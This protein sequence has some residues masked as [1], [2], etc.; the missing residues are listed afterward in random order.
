MSL[1]KRKK[2][3]VAVGTFIAVLAIF[4]IALYYCEREWV[5]ISG[6]EGELSKNT[7]LDAG[8]GMEE[9]SSSDRIFFQCNVKSGS[10]IFELSDTSGMIVFRKEFVS[11][12]MGYFY[13]DHVSEGI[14]TDHW[15]TK[16]PESIVSYDASHQGNKSRYE[17]V[18]KKK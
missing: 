4:F 8:E 6:M 1:K 3:I 16:D 18:F 5:T 13:F 11:S 7:Y 12:E 2:L 14:Y 15:Y 10:A 17:R 9:Y